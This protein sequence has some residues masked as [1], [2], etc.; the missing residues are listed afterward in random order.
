M[1]NSLDN[2]MGIVGHAVAVVAMVFEMPVESC[3]L[4]VMRAK[5][6]A[7]SAVDLSMSNT[8]FVVPKPATSF[9]RV[10]E[11]GEPWIA[12]YRCPD[13]GAVVLEKTLACRRCTSRQ[14]LREFRATDCGRIYT[15][16]VVERSFP[17]VAVPFISVIVDLDDGLT[18]K[19]TLRGGQST[20]INAGMP[21]RLVFDDAGGA[22]DSNDTPYVGYHFVPLLGEVK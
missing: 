12:G 13:C 6:N 21:V 19:G 11:G 15:W 8:L 16:S 20:S 17:G 9:I 18:L 3:I 5:F 22:R 1:P 10:E 14:E 4:R 2:S 7:N